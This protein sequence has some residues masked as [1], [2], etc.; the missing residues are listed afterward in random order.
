MI[1]R[2]TAIDIARKRAAEKGWGL[3]EPVDVFERRDWKDGMKYFEIESNAGNLGTK[4]RFVVDAKTGEIV[5]DG[6]VPR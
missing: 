1:D 2:D 6:Y 5:S 3:A 4:A